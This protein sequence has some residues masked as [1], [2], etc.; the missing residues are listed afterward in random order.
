[1][2]LRE[3]DGVEDHVGAV[4]DSDHSHLVERDDPLNGSAHAVEDLAELD[5][6]GSDL[7][8]LGENAGYQLSING[9]GC[10]A[11]RFPFAVGGLLGWFM[12]GRG[13]GSGGSK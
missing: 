11:H 5:R 2:L 8:D 12:L 13:L 1:M 7:G 6:L 9:S 3:R 10:E 4:D